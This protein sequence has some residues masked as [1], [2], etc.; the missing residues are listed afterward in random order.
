MPKIIFI[1]LFL[2]SLFK[3]LAQDTVYA[4]QLINKLTSKH[5]FGRGY[6]NNGLK[7]AEQIIIDELK[8]NSPEPLFNGS[9][10]QSFFHNV[11]TFPNDCFVK[12]NGKVLIPGVDYI[13]NPSSNKLKGKFNL[14]KKDS[15]SYTATLHRGTVVVTKK[16]KL[17]FS[18]STTLNN[19]CEIELDKKRFS[20]EP[21]TIKLEIENNFITNF[22]SK[23]IGC[24]IKGSSPSDSLVVFSAHY[25]HLGGIGKNTYFAGANDNA[26]GVSAV[27]NLINYYTTTKPRYTTV[28]IFFAGE[29]AGLLGSKY[30]VDKKSIDLTKIKFL[31][32]LDLLGTGDDGIMVTNGYVFEKQFTLL[33]AINIKNNLVNSVKRRGKAANSDHYWFTEAGVPSFFIYTLGGISAYHDVYDQAKTLPL[34]EYVDVFTLL[35][36]FV[37]QL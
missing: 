24:F 18:V 3:C 14:T 16:N 8:L 28:F 31:I 21:K 34:T 10:T 12:L 29:E 13:L 35:V 20:D 26:S 27:L 6:T 5:C 22:E 2:F 15:V 33:N 23:N 1:S 4:R 7:N 30:F 32:N 25:D 11:N 37:E 36:K 9:F 17:T 19:Y